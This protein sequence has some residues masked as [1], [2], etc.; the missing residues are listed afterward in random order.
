M[1]GGPARSA[2][3]TSSSPGRPW[4]RGLRRRSRHQPQLLRAGPSPV[5]RR[6]RLT[7]GPGAGKLSW[8]PRRPVGSGRGIR[9]IRRT[10]WPRRLLRGPVDFGGGASRGP[11]EWTCSSKCRGVDVAGRG[12]GATA[13]RRVSTPMRSPTTTPATFS[14]PGLP[15]DRLAAALPPSPGTQ[16]STSPLASADGGYRGAQLRRDGLTVGSAAGRDDRRREQRDPRRVIG[17][18]DSAAVPTTSAAPAPARATGVTWSKNFP[19]AAA[20][21]AAAWRWAGGQ[22]RRHRRL[23]LDRIPPAAAT[24]VAVPRDRLLLTVPAS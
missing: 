9:G 17:S 16:T 8:R 24:F 4:H 11:A 18:A 20:V 19:P 13:T 6:Q 14:S 15:R 21:R 23:R 7:C 2:G 1:K 22:D 12:L 3:D 10:T 5:L